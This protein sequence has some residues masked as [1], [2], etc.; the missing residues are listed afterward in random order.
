[1]KDPVILDGEHRID[2]NELLKWW[3]EDKCKHQYINFYTGKFVAT[4]EYDTALKEESMQYLKYSQL[5]L[6]FYSTALDHSLFVS[7]SRPE[8]AKPKPGASTRISLD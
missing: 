4:I 8:S 3:S 1:M 2:Y 6:S 7:R 5:Y